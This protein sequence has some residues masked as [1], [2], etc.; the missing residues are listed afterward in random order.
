MEHF[1]SFY[2]TTVNRDCE[3]GEWSNW[4]EPSGVGIIERVRLVKVKELGNG[5]CPALRETKTSEIIIELGLCL[6]CLS[7][8]FQFYNGGQ[9]GNKSIHTNKQHTPSCLYNND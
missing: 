2:D 9:L 7:A 6:R 5:T 3:L 1:F 8:I 4:T